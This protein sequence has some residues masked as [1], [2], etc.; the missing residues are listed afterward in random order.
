MVMLR[1]SSTIPFNAKSRV[2]GAARSLALVSAAPNSYSM[3]ELSVLDKLETELA[4]VRRARAAARLEILS[5]Q[6]AEKSARFL[7]L[8][9]GL[10]S[11][12]N[13]RFF[14]LRLEQALAREPRSR[15]SLAVLYFDLD[16]FKQLNDAHGHHV[17]DELLRIVG[18]RLAHAVRA[19]DMVSRLGGDEFVCLRTGE[20][21][22]N[23]L[24]A[25]ACKLFDAVR[26]PMRIGRHDLSVRPSIGIAIAPDDGLDA[27]E[28]MQHADAAMYRA[29]RQRSGHEFYSPQNAG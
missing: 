17:G 25:L 26:A 8:H 22:R 16:G 1:T 11:L 18:S 27:D 24:A 5:I 21:G 14:R 4:G 3:P 29:K 12:P 28:L 10:T 6:S 9:D 19:E 20:P 15:Q 7:A 2:S 13:L 23:Q